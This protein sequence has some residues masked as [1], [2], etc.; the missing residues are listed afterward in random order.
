VCSRQLPKDGEVFTLESFD[1]AAVLVSLSLHMPAS[2]L[3]FDTGSI[4]ILSRAMDLKYRQSYVLQIDED[5]SL[6]S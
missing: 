6:A 5:A 4:C 2:V 3:C 1:C